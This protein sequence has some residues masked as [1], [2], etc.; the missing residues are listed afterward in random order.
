MPQ[1][2]ARRN[3]TAA[4]IEE[5]PP[6][7]PQTSARSGSMAA[8]TGATE[9]NASVRPGRPSGTGTFVFRRSVLSYNVP[10]KSID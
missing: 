7:V 9:K 2:S 10:S 4:A 8:A 5:R 1:T 3:D 6:A